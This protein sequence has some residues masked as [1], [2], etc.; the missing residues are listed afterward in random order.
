MKKFLLFIG[1]FISSLAWGQDK[2]SYYIDLNKLVKDRL[3]IKV[4]TPTFKQKEVVYALPK[5]VPGTY[6]NY[7]FGRFVQDFQ[8]IDKNGKALKFK[9]TGPN[10]YQISQASSLAEI[11]YWVDD[12]WDSPEIAG[13]YVFE[14]AGTSFQ[15]DSLFALNTHAMLG[16]FIGHEKV[17]VEL[18]INKPQPFYG[19]SSLQNTSLSKTD[20]FLAQN[21]QDLIDAPLMYSAPDTVSF[22]LANAQI[23]ISV[24]SPNKMC[25]ASQVAEQIKPLLEAQKKYLGGQL[26]VNKYAFIIVLSDNIKNGSYGALEHAQSSFYYLPEGNIQTLAETIREVCAHEFFHIVTPLNIHSE[27]IGNFNFLQPK[28]SKHLWLY[29]GLTEYA[30]HH[31]QLKYQLTDLKKFMSTFENKWDVMNVQFDRNLPFTTMSEKVLDKYKDEYGNVYQKGAWLGFGLD[32]TLR[33]LSQGKYGTQEMM[34]DLAKFYGPHQ[35]FKDN[36]LFDQLV[37]ITAQPELK[38]FFQ[39]YVE[40]KEEI[41][42]AD[43]LHSIGYE[44]QEFDARDIK[45][46]GFDFQALNIN[47]ETHRAVINSEEGIHEFGKM[48]GLKAKDE[49]LMVNQ[50]SLSIDSFSTNVAKV[51]K[52][53]Q[54]G[55]IVELEIARPTGNGNYETIRLKAPFQ[56]SMGNAPRTFVPQKKP[57]DAQ[58]KLREQ[59]MNSIP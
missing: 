7:D 9:K 54:L 45:S 10:T 20:I 15:A 6:A 29:E 56:T 34:R 48:L 43:W 39:K 14:P 30:A 22:P 38:S 5:I 3:E 41:P 40:G 49:L 1:L 27:E 21:Y 35:S 52:D 42:V 8:A 16:Y 26:P 25:S 32:L 24:Y 2:V 53:I 17:A 51:L 33:K 55:D 46:L 13:D 50:L 57:S 36:E 18:S 11:R 23:L 47:S 12:T 31:V 44:I 37:K 19:G 28:M 4:K 59:W 58:L